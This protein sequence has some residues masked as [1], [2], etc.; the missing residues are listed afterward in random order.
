MYNSTRFVICFN[1]LKKHQSLKTDFLN[2]YFLHKVKFF[3]YIYQ[4]CFGTFFKSTNKYPGYL[5]GQ[6]FGACI[7]INFFWY[8]GKAK[9]DRARSVEYARYSILTKFW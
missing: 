1:I 5:V 7:V 4:S 6:V 9:K 3:Q 2:L 8:S